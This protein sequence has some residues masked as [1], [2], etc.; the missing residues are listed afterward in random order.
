[1]HIHTGTQQQEPKDLESGNIKGSRPREL[2]KRTE[3][4]LSPVASFYETCSCKYNSNSET[5]LTV[6]FC[7]QGQGTLEMH[8]KLII[9]SIP[10]KA[11]QKDSCHVMF[12]D[13]LEVVCTVEVAGF[14]TE[15]MVLV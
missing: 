1:M 2:Q 10:S 12:I 4:A 15:F 7:R 13:S 14:L 8:S 11:C 5:E 6:T 9:S 3:T